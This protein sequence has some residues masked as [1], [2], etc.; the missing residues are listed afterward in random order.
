MKQQKELK[1]TNFG[2][3]LFASIVIEGDALF[4]DTT[5]ARTYT[6]KELQL[7]ANKTTKRREKKTK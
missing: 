5:T 3:L 7:K 1:E 6:K 2:R 4:F